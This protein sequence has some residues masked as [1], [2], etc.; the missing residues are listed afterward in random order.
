MA[1]G[2]WLKTIV[3][4]LTIDDTAFSDQLKNVQKGVLA[5]SASVTA[6]GAA[7]FAAAKFTANYQDET[8]KASRAAGVATKE[9]SELAYAAKFSGVSTEALTKSITKMNT[10][11]KEAAQTFKDLG[12]NMKDAQG[13]AKSSTQLLRDVA[14]RFAKIQDPA[15]KSQAAIRLFGERGKEMVSMLDGGSKAL[16]EAAKEAAKFGQVV[17]QDAGM[18]AEKFN[19]D[20]ARMGEALSGARNAI[21]ESIIAFINQTGV[22]EAAAEV[23][24]KVIAYWNSL[25][26]DTKETVMSL[27]ALVTIVVAIVTG[28]TALAAVL[29][30]VAAGFALMMGPVG[31]VIAGIAAL[32][33]GITYFTGATK[34]AVETA[35]QMSQRHQKEASDLASL[36]SA[37]SGVAGKK[38]ENAQ[39]STTQAAAV[40]QLEEAAKKYNVSLTN[41]LGVYKSLKQV[42]VEILK[43]QRDELVN[44][45]N[46]VRVTRDQAQANIVA[47]TTTREWSQMLAQWGAS[48]QQSNMGANFVQQTQ[49]LNALNNSLNQYGQQIHAANVAINQVA[50]STENLNNQTVSLSNNA[51]TAA[52]R[53]EKLRGA[54]GAFQEAEGYSSELENS[55]RRLSDVSRSTKTD[56]VDV[57][58]A[59][60][61]SFKELANVASQVIGPIVG[62]SEAIA[63]GI[64]YTASVALRDL[65]VVAMRSAELYKKNREMIEKEENAKAREIQAGYDK[66][67]DALR[68]GENAKTMALEF[69]INERLLLLND[70]YQ[71][72]KAQEEANFK[73]K[74]ERDRAQFEIEKA[75]L[76]EKAIDKEQR[77]LVDEQME[78]DY[79]A[80][81]ENQQREHEARLN[82]MAKE[83][84]SA[85]RE[86][87][88]SAKAELKGLELENKAEIEQLTKE[89]AEALAAAEEEKNKRLQELDD[90]RTKQ[91]KEQEKK[92]LKIQYEAELAAFKQ[93]QGA[94]IAE[95]I[96]SGIAGA[97]QA[98]AALAPIPFVGP[99]L[100]AAAAAVISATMAIRVNQLRSQQP[101]KPAGLMLEDGGF[102]GGDRTH[103][104]GGVPA[105]VESGEFVID[106]RRTQMM[107][108]AIENASGGGQPINIYFQDGSIRNLDVDSE[109]AAERIG[110]II[111]QQLRRQGVAA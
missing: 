60:A 107:Y 32:A 22:M 64:R 25:S 56:F 99:A 81:R 45:M 34:N 38:K 33:A 1:S 46:L 111:G 87:T 69:A 63:D 15:V 5:F 39:L 51:A 82:D 59:G 71:K 36:Q 68:A 10:P 44:K 2:K 90:A 58:I 16:D 4:K 109:Q 104:H 97:A 65:E 91:E 54:S 40:K 29:P 106:R 85:E 7:A 28:F 105:E 50:N 3:T 53:W 93:T 35:D 37:Y 49:N 73:A 96:A 6:A 61:A 76:L 72:A 86:M 84:L 55:L 108:K 26:D 31:L 66:Q 80:W 102:I 100:G 13:Q 42:R 95:T 14:D 74:M 79:K 83:H 77:Q 62:L 92:R 24:S 19:D 47:L 52:N 78:A 43:G 23:I 67:I 110:V 27:A 98:F 75:L 11:S 12:V 8:I 17:T 41:E 70:E 48:W 9:F 30:A 101:I 18:A 94:R 88:A 21:G 57:G 103:A 20:L 89:K